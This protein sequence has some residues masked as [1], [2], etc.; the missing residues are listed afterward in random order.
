MCLYV[1]CFGSAKSSNFSQE[2]D[3]WSAKGAC[4]ILKICTQNYITK[5]K[6][7]KLHTPKLSNL[8]PPVSSVLFQRI[9]IRLS[10]PEQSNML[11]L[12][13]FRRSTS[14]TVHSCFRDVQRALMLHV[15]MSYINRKQQARSIS[16]L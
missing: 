15:Q 11:M 6:Y 4:S 3:P 9:K 16:V 1:A 14:A 13:L 8:N 10:S 7:L 5:L 2:P 12:K